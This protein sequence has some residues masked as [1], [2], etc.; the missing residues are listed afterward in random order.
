MHEPFRSSLAANPGDSFIGLMYADWLSEQGADEESYWR[1]PRVY[2]Q[3]WTAIFDGHGE[4]K[5][6]G[7]GR[8][9]IASEDDEGD[10]FGNCGVEYYTRDYG[11][12][13]DRH[14]YNGGNGY[15]W[16]FGDS[17]GNGPPINGGKGY[18]QSMVGANNPLDL[19]DWMSYSEMFFG[20][21][22]RY[23]VLMEGRFVLVCDRGFVLVGDVSP[24]PSDWQRVI[25]DQCATVRIWG[26]TG[27]LGQLALEGPQSST[28]LDYEGDGVDV[29]RATILRAIPCNETAWEN[30]PDAFLHQTE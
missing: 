26:T 9:D 8:G 2:A 13:Y 3:V 24:H 30:Y 11:A 25:V 17:S 21:L 15:G 12:H 29:L 7:F 6:D 5:G 27:G 20:K 4:S 19:W 14:N 23:E 16:G 22:L 1:D 10:G 28:I 18:G